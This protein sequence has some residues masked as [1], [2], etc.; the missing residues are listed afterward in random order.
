MNCPWERI[1]RFSSPRELQRFL[2]WMG[3]QIASGVAE[4]IGTPADQQVI[5]GERW[6]KHVSSGARWRLAPADGPLAPGFW[7]VEN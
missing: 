6:F 7:P 4:E 5:T 1:G 2:K 3:E